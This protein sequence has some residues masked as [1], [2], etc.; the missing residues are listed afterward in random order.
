LRIC[1]SISRW[2][3]VLPN[4]SERLLCC[5]LH[6]SH[7]SLIDLVR[8][9]YWPSIQL[10][11]GTKLAIEKFA[12]GVNSPSSTTPH[13]QSPHPH[14]PVSPTLSISMS[15]HSP[16]QLANVAQASQF[17]HPGGQLH[18]S[19]SSNEVASTFT[20]TL[21][22]QINETIGFSGAANAKKRY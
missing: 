14:S 19:P 15:P 17:T 22:N 2:C 13:S 16:P 9:Q 7:A 1:L 3:K 11:I 5:S 20:S 12:S 18:R 4:L 21:L 6:S 8:S 10:P